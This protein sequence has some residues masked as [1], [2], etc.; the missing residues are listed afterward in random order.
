MGGTILIVDDEVEI[1]AVLSEFLEQKGYTVFQAHDVPQARG[2]LRN[3][4]HPDLVILDV[5]LKGGDGISFLREIRT[6]VAPR[7]V[8]VIMVSAHRTSASDRVSGLETGADDYMSKPFDLRELNLRIER[9]LKPMRGARGDRGAKPSPEDMAT[10]LKSLLDKKTFPYPP[11][12][13][14]PARETDMAPALADVLRGNDPSELPGAGDSSIAVPSENRTAMKQLVREYFMLL[15]E[16]RRF[17]STVTERRLPA[18]GY[19][20]VGLAGLCV[21][22]Q[23]GFET[24]TIAAAFI[25][26][27]MY[28]ALYLGGAAIIAWLIQWVRGLQRKPISFRIVFSALSLGFA[29]LVL[30][31]VLA[32]AYV[33]I[34]HG[35]TG[36]FTAG[37]LLAFPAE[38]AA[39]HLGFLLRRLDAFELWSVWLAG[40]AM[41]RALS[42]KKRNGVRWAFAAWGTAVAVTSLF[43][44]IFA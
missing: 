13:V 36:D 14:A 6:S 18:V 32:S 2:H 23:E 3:G 8:P 12:T 31:G 37:P 25:N 17:F 24:K 27:L 33:A 21:G 15:L 34:G 1:C 29:P 41:D 44:G 26:S 30:A 35:R 10:V 22:I 7:E 5:V 43:I 42:G 4:L 20:S 9:L 28:P 38:G 16:P 11:A 39:R 19:L 40:V